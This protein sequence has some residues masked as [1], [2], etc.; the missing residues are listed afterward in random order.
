MTLKIG[1]GIILNLLMLTGSLACQQPSSSV[2]I[3]YPE[4]GLE[5]NPAT[6]GTGNNR[7]LNYSIPLE[8]LLDSIKLINPNLKI[9]VDKSHYTLSLFADSLLIKQYPVVFGWNPVDDKLRE[10][11]GCT[12]EG[13]YK[14]LAKYNHPLWS[15]FIW[16]DYPNKESLAKFHKAKSNG[17]IPPESTPG[18][19][20]GIHG[21]PANTDY[22]IDQGVNWTAGCVALKNKDIID[23]YNYIDI[24]TEV[25]IRK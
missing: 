3:N 22:A 19:Q 1:V 6:T 11:D 16:I 24:G 8:I 14:V 12:P 25:I 7:L 15:K 18:G 5:Q 23:M 13:N 9:H 21:V 17:I 10:G 2:R 20:I 4:P